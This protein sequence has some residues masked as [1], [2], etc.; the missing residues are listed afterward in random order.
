MSMLSEQSATF[1]YLQ[2]EKDSFGKIRTIGNFLNFLALFMILCEPS[3]L[4]VQ[5]LQS[6]IPPRAVGGS[7]NLGVPVVLLRA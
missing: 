3:E 6:H 4:G 7:E 2:P 5:G 1:V